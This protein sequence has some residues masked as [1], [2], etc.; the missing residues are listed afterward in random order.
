MKEARSEKVSEEV[1]ESPARKKGGGATNYNSN[2]WQF[3]ISAPTNDFEHC[4]FPFISF[5]EGATSVRGQ[6]H[7]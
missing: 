3:S 4:W 6:V 2:Y 5:C 1:R 7:M